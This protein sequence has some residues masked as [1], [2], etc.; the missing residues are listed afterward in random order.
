M[1]DGL[2]LLDDGWVSPPPVVD[3]KCEF[4]E[5][6]MDDVHVVVRCTRRDEVLYPGYPYGLVLRVSINAAE[7]AEVPTSKELL[8]QLLSE[9]VTTVG[10]VVGYCGTLG[11][12]ADALREQGLR[13]FDPRTCLFPPPP[14]GIEFDRVSQQNAADDEAEIVVDIP[15]IWNLV[16]PYLNP[17]CFVAPKGAIENGRLRIRPFVY[18]TLRQFVRVHWLNCVSMKAYAGARL[19]NAVSVLLL[20]PLRAKAIGVEREV[21]VVI[22]DVYINGSPTTGRLAPC[23]YDPTSYVLTLAEPTILTGV[24]VIVVPTHVEMGILLLFDQLPR[25]REVQS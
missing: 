3:F 20:K 7:G 19:V 14:S 10:T 11:S 18:Y 17:F 16:N 15:L 9:R 2:E 6:D 8:H 23:R 24:E 5:N 13:P 21:V 1:D 22:E 25:V 4:Y 12:V